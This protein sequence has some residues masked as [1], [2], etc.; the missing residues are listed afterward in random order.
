MQIKYLKL[1]KILMWIPIL[2]VVAFLILIFSNISQGNIKKM[3]IPMVIWFGIFFGAAIVRA[4]ATII[5]S[6]FQLYTVIDIVTYGTLYLT[7]T[8]GCLLLPKQ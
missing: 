4:I 5:L 2:N 7:F 8:F 6:Q 1:Q 3:L